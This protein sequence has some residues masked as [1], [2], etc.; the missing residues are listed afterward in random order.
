MDGLTDGRTDLLAYWGASTEGLITNQYVYQDIPSGF[1]RAPRQI[2]L[3]IKTE[4]IRGIW[5]SS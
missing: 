1:S 4:K 2:I 3:S 5:D